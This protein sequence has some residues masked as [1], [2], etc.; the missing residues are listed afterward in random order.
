VAAVDVD[1][2]DRSMCISGIL[3]ALVWS[4]RSLAL[5]HVIPLAEI[6]QFSWGI[7]ATTKVRGKYWNN[8]FKKLGYRDK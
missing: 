6:R 7:G 3:A 5:S 1:W 8:F 4:S 2:M